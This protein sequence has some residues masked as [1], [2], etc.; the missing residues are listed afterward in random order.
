MDV[1]YPLYICLCMSWLGTSRLDKT[2]SQA[3]TKV[4]NHSRNGFFLLVILLASHRHSPS[5]VSHKTR[6][7]LRRSGDF[8]MDTVPMRDNPMLFIAAS[9]CLWISRSAPSSPCC[10]FFACS[11]SSWSSLIWLVLSLSPS[12]L[13]S[14][15]NNHGDNI[16]NT[17][18]WTIMG[19]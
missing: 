12:Q 4:P 1:M 18:L 15:I 14:A 6:D 13:S 16:D 10:L 7:L 8:P 3:N 19:H 5:S 9:I 11:W 2:G 17:A